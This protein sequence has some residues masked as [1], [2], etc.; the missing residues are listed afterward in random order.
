MKYIVYSTV[1]KANNKIYIGVH[2]TTDPEIF[3]GYIG[4]G[5]NIYQPGHL[6]SLKP[7]P[8]RNAVIKYGFSNFIRSIIKIFDDEKDAYEFEALLVDEE[9]VKREDTYN[10]AL[11]GHSTQHANP[12]KAVY[13]YDLDGNFEMEFS[14]INE[15]GRYLN[16]SARGAGHLTRAIKLGH[17]YLGHQFS[18]EKLPYMKKL[19]HRKLNGVA[20]GNIGPKVGQYD[21]QGN[22]I[23]IFET[24]TDCVKAGFKNAKQVA[25]GK[26]AKCKGFIFK[27]LN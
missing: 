11:G 10:L 20:K 24:M 5:I 8:F 17:Q 25:L 13:M 12:K 15:A 26:R 21:E 14:G 2:G 3:D 22:L 27:Y 18:Y 9:F 19:K 16:H 7:T 6:R 23:Q 4:C 1:C